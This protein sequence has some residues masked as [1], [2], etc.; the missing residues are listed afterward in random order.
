MSEQYVEALAEILR[1]SNVVMIPNESATDGNVFSAQNV[2]QTI[3]MYKQLMG[4]NKQQSERMAQ[5]MGTGTQ[6]VLNRI[7]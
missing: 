7:V 1:K 4:G 6:D 5:A 3:T 2:A